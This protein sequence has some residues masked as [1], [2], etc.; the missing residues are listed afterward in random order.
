VPATR[1][2]SRRSSSFTTPACC[3]T[4]PCPPAPAACCA[5][6]LAALIADV[7]AALQQGCVAS[8]H[9]P[10]RLPTAR[11]VSRP[12]R[13]SCSEPRSMLGWPRGL[14][15][16]SKKVPLV[17]LLFRLARLV[18][19]W[20]GPWLVNRACVSAGSLMN[21]HAC[22]AQPYSDAHSR[23]TYD[24]KKRPCVL[25]PAR[26]STGE[27]TRCAAEA[28]ER[29][30]PACRDQLE[31][32]KGR[33]PALWQHDPSIP[34]NH[35]GP[36]FLAR[37]A[38]NAYVKPR[39]FW[40]TVPS[41]AAFTQQLCCVSAAAAV[42]LLLHQQRVTW[43]QLLAA[44]GALLAAGYVACAA[45]GGHQLGG[46][47]V[48]RSPAQPPHQ[49][50]PPGAKAR[51]HQHRIVFI[52][53]WRPPHA[54]P[55]PHATQGRGARQCALLVGGERTASN[56]HPQAPPQPHLHSLPAHCLGARSPRPLTHYPWAA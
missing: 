10:G 3:W 38:V 26:T 29:P 7:C 14:R 54:V 28:R 5:R 39:R 51:P 30:L 55:R 46:G 47:L 17:V 2:E 36:D 19:C 24:A 6:T 8:A 35:T 42:A 48:G 20:A 49:L 15:S 56:P 13:L 32:P 37:L 53:L 21:R 27:A 4:G 44:C 52:V 34:D 22:L 40:A 50:Q 1:R 31:P 33:A 41:T 12:K 23:S 16:V 11:S 25:Q 45:L 43:Q 18:A 9:N